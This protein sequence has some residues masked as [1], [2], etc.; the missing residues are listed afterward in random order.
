MDNTRHGLRTKC[1]EKCL[2]ILD[3]TAVE[4]MLADISLSGALI[5][6]GAGMTGAAPGRECR[7]HL[8]SS[9][10]VCPT[11]Y[12]CRI[13]RVSPGEIGVAFITSEGLIRD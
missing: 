12:S 13:A 9:T 10:E 5:R 4:G 1:L 11:A 7:L 3:G 2:F 6:T 8:C